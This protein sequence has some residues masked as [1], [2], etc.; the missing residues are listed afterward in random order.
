VPSPLTICGGVYF[1]QR[2]T[3]C[4]SLNQN[5]WFSIFEFV[6]PNIKSG[7]FGSWSPFLRENR[8]ESEGRNLLVVPGYLF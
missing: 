4:A 1:M 6:A 5:N 8:N 3:L 2:H 7:T